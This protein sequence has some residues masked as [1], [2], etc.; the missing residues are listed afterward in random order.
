MEVARRKGK[1]PRRWLMLQVGAPP[2]WHPTTTL[3]SAGDL[4]VQIGLAAGVYCAESMC[5]EDL[6]DR[7]ED[8]L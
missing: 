2:R 5:S 6:L 3:V 7:N 1:Q 4:E 8:D